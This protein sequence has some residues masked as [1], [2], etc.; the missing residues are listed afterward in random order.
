MFNTLRKINIF[1]GNFGSGKTEI[2]LNFALELH[3]QGREVTIV[4]LDIINPYF[5]TRTVKEGLE[6]A[7]VAVVCPERRMMDADLPALSPAIRGVLEGNRGYG[8][9]D[10]GGDEIGTIALGRFRDLL[11]AGDYS[12]FMVVNT[13]RPFT[14][15]ID[16]IIRQ[17][18]G[19]ERAARV[20]V[21]ALVSNVNL[22][23]ET[24][25]ETVRDGHRAVAGAAAKLGLPV[26][27]A[28]VRRDL[29]PLAR[30]LGVPVLPLD[31]FMKP[32]WQEQGF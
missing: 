9:V 30:D 10:V 16:G 26:A 12:L 24:T 20:N 14:G 31:L 3:R 6:A 32:P 4:D 29:A 13:C 19:I 7:G 23:P 25:L 21:T 11:P 1:T 8:A 22:G 2:T 27:F 5:R 17:L 15:D 28:G 18:Q